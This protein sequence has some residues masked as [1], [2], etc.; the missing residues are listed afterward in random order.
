MLDTRKR[1][2]VDANIISCKVIHEFFNLS[3]V[4]IG[5]IF[6]KHHATVIHYVNLW[7][8]TLAFDKECHHLYSII[9]DHTIRELYGDKLE[10]NDVELD[11]LNILQLRRVVQDLR[12]ENSSLKN[13]LFN[14]Q[15]AYNA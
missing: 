5:S 4:G 2:I 15:A 6:N 14:I 9:C 8:N 12:L 10:L 11:R 13:K 3:T 7:N 1:A